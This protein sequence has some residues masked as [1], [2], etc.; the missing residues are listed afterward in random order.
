[1]RYIF[2][3]LL[4]LGQLSIYV[5]TM[6]LVVKVLINKRVSLAKNIMGEVDKTIMK[7][8]IDSINETFNRRLHILD[9]N[10]SDVII[11]A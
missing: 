1:M 2:N 9:I 10:Q 3:P 5:I 11:F 7:V 4:S 6:K 8:L